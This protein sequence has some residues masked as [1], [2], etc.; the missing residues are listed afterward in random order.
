MI[1]RLPSYYQA[2]HANGK[3]PQRAALNGKSPFL[4]KAAACI[5][6]YPA[7]ALGVAFTAGLIIGR[8]VKR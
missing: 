2:P 4:A 3:H 8:L 7:A 5:G 1:N 6:A